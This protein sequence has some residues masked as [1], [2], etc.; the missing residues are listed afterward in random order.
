MHFKQK[1][2]HRFMLLVVCSLNYIVKHYLGDILKVKC[3]PLFFCG[4]SRLCIWAFMVVQ[5]YAEKPWYLTSVIVTHLRQPASRKCVIIV[6]QFRQLLKTVCTHLPPFN[7]S[8]N[9]GGNLSDS[10]TVAVC[11]WCVNLILLLIKFV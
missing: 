2:K 6:T 7:Y 5:C 1:F 9:N 8:E 4:L 11:G 3:C 10:D